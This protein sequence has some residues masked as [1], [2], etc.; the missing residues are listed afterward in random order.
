MEH[1]ANEFV[2]NRQETRLTAENRGESRLRYNWPIW[3]AENY[4]DILSQ[5][6]M[7]DICSGGAAFTCYADKCPYV[8]QEV[9]T[10]FSVPSHGVDDPFAM[11]NFVKNGS[12]CRIDEISPHVRR[13]AV[14]FAEPLPF[15][16]GEISEDDTFSDAAGALESISGELVGQ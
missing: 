15:K 2:N 3:F 11:E 8:G 7:V 10:R 12:I 1:L 5:G 14:Q 13:V 16:P 9:T 4:D 6:Q